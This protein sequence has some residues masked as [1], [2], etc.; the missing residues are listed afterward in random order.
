MMAITSFLLISVFFLDFLGLFPATLIKSS[1]W[2]QFVPSLLLFSKV[3]SISAIGFILILIIT[4]L[5]GRVYC[6]AFCPLGIFQ[7]VILRIARLFKKIRFKYQPPISWVRNFVLLFTILTAFTGSTIILN[8]L[9]P[10]SLFGRIFSDVFRPIVILGN[11]GLASLLQSQD[12]YTIYHVHF[13]LMHYSLYVV[14]VGFLFLIAYLTVIH[15][16]VYCNT[17]CP[18][19]TLLGH[20]SKYSLYKLYIDK[21]TCTNCKACERVCKAE[22]IDLKNKTIDHSRCISCYNCMTSCKNSGINL[23]RKPKSEEAVKPA[24]IDTSRRK[25]LSFLAGGAI[26]APAETLAQKVVSNSASV[27]ENRQQYVTPPGS[28]DVKEF[29][30]R[31]TGCHLCVTAC[32]TN[33]IQPSRDEFGWRHIMQVRMDFHSGFCNFEC[34]RCTE[35]CP[36]G[37]LTPLTLEDKKI[38]QLGRAEFIKAN[39]IVNTEE[40]DCGACSEHCPT[41]A[42]HMVPYKNGLTIPE[43]DESICIGCGACEFACPTKPFKA[44]YIKGNAVHV[45]A[46]KPQREKAKKTEFEGDFPF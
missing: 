34:Q 23:L 14:P 13:N 8:M 35:V 11:N 29:L 6:A 16:R 40:T 33:V 45:L 2:L 37:A 17:I 46:D 38:T 3:F 44:I 30:T 4:S 24:P 43:V 21:N 27:P 31:C 39:C 1:L 19:G 32:P 10:Y 9:D 7:D 22:C 15:G 5:F 12:I 42:V 36:T 25:A 41:K 28:A 20:I 18:V 26:L